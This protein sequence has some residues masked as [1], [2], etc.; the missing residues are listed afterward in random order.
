MV[1]TWNDPRQYDK[2]GVTTIFLPRNTNFGNMIRRTGDAAIPRD[3][4]PARCLTLIGQNAKRQ[5]FCRCLVVENQTTIDTWSAVFAT[6]LT[7]SM[8]EAQWWTKFASAT[9]LAAS[10][11]CWLVN[12]EIVVGCQ[13][14]N[15]KLV[16]TRR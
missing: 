4:I 13:E 1:G 6:C 10:L 5:G 11:R 3:E 14:E 7:L 16:K 15:I 9:L 8:T 12:K 2:K